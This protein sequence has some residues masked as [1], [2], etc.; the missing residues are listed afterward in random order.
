MR[1][2]STL[3]QRAA[4][5]QVAFL[6]WCLAFFGV[7]PL[8]VNPLP[9]QIVLLVAAAVLLA[10]S[11]PGMFLATALARVGER[12]ARR[13][14]VLFA[15]ALPLGLTLIGTGL[16]MDSYRIHAAEQDSSSLWR[17][18]FDV[19]MVIIQGVSL[20]VNIATLSRSSNPGPRGSGA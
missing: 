8:Q 18:I 14:I 4:L 15:I 10:G 16:V 7:D 13:L 3:F 2:Y 1:D 11:L 12:G 19:A 9:I 20:G 17:L 5:G 6:V